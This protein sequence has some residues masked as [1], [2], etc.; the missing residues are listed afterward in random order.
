M[1]S[2]IGRHSDN[3]LGQLSCFDRIIIQGALPDICYPGVQYR[4]FRFRQP[5]QNELLFCDNLNQLSLK[6]I[7][8]VKPANC[9][10]TIVEIV[11]YN[12]SIRRSSG[13]VSSRCHSDHTDL[14]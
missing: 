1:T 6:L 12:R 11:F 9:R 14:R 4:Q 8:F 7:K 10:K 13:N 5:C 2:F 3:V